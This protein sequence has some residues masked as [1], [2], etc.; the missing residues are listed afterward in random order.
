MTVTC[1]KC[2][3]TLDP[4][5]NSMCKICGRGRCC[6]LLWTDDD[7]ETATCGTCVLTGAELPQ[8][9]IN[10]P[11]G[12][13]GAVMTEEMK[14]EEQV[15]GEK[16]EN[17]ETCFETPTTDEKP[18][19]A[20]NEVRQLSFREQLMNKRED[21]VEEARKIES[22]LCVLDGCSSAERIVSGMVE[23][24]VLCVR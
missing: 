22:A 8:E 12:P 2:E 20:S 4:A 19:E 1:S 9:R 15:E 11:N 24:G 18:E 14:V 3:K 13:E 16:V 10:R 21:L 23:D 17:E 6:A 5:I 7:N